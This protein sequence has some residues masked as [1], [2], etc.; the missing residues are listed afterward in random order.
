MQFFVAFHQGNIIAIEQPIDLLSR[1]GEQLI[2]RGWPFEFLLG[3]RLVIEHKAVVLPHQALDLVAAAIG[4]GIEGTGEWIVPELLLDQRRQAIGLFAKIDGRPVEVDLRQSQG[5]SQ[6][7]RAHY[8]SLM[9]APSN[10]ILLACR[11]E[12]AMPLGKVR[13]KPGWVV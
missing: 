13:V 5:R 10:S 2:G 3:E 12:M 7:T 4:E 11:P 9:I 1:E 8:K 6:V